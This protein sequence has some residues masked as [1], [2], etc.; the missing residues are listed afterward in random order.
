MKGAMAITV[1]LVWVVEWLLPWPLSLLLLGVLAATL[2][3]Q[4]SLDQ[5]VAAVA[6][7]LERGGAEAG[8]QAVGMIVGRD[9]GALDE[10]GVSRGASP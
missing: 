4:R 2:I 5:H 9:T 10:A 6:D 1:A 3:A 7:A 8:R